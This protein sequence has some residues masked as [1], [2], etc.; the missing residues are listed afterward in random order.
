MA[1]KLFRIFPFTTKGT[2]GFPVVTAP[3]KLVA[4]GTNENEINTVSVSYTTEKGT[5]TIS[6]D[7]SREQKTTITGYSVAVE[8]YGINPDAI[9][10]LGLAVKD[11]NGNLI[12]TTENTKHVCLFAKSASQKGLKKE[13][14][15]YDVVAQ[16]LDE[17][18]KTQLKNEVADLITLNFTGSLLSTT[19]FGDVPFS[20]VFEG[21][22]GYITGDPSATDFYKGAAAI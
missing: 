4:P 1:C 10:A 14:W 21:N 6:A 22:T 11:V 20:E 8:A 16:P 18:F 15:F 3:V 2:D 7:D 19:A 5:V 9:A 17:K 12:F 13:S